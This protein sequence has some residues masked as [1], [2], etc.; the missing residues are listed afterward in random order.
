MNLDR[1]REFLTEE[2]YTIL[3]DCV[4][5]MQRCYEAQGEEFVL[6]LDELESDVRSY[7]EGQDS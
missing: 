1:F 5:F 7:V 2:Q 3:E 4:V 6:D